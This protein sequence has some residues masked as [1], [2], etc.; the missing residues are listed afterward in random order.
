MAEDHN[1]L[2]ELREEM[3]RMKFSLMNRLPGVP[4]Y[5]GALHESYLE[6]IDAYKLAASSEGWDDR[7]TASQLWRYL[8]KAARTFWS[9][10]ESRH[11]WAWLQPVLYQHF[12]PPE[13][14]RFHSDLL[15]QRHQGL[16]ESLAEYACDVSKLV[17][18]AFPNIEG[19]AR[20]DLLRTHF[21]RGLKPDLLFHVLTVK[22]G[23]SY[24]E[25]YQLAQNFETGKQ[26]IRQA[27]LGTARETAGGGQVFAGFA[28]PGNPSAP[29][30][31]GLVPVRDRPF[32]Q[33]YNNASC[34]NCRRRGHFAR[35]CREAETD[36]EYRGSEY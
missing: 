24:I 9:E 30:G 2:R 8:D 14:S 29:Q 28:M 21:V 12:V 13:V 20:Q 33:N 31:P 3:E 27:T 6:F 1:E 34:H 16:N 7:R 19:D 10:Q 4:V 17:K 25:S 22:P 35:E 23:A 11:D 5:T 15:L 32:G 36:G 18:N 26:L